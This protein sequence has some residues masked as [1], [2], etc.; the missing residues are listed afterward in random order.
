MSKVM[1]F[2]LTKEVMSNEEKIE[3]KEVIDDKQ[4]IELLAKGTL[5]DKKHTVVEGDVFEKIADEYDLTTEELLE[6]NSDLNVDSI[7]QI[8][9]EL[10][11]TVLEPYTEVRSEERRVGKECRCRWDACHDNRKRM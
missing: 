4:G 7:L 11:V 5:E 8:D 10:N 9:Q 6:L 1:P 3:Q 2:K